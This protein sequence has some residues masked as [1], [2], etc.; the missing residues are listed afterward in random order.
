M[1][2][3]KPCPF[4]GGDAGMHM[5]TTY[6]AKGQKERSQG[7]R[8][9]CK[10]CKAQTQLV[11]CNLVESVANRINNATDTKEDAKRIVADAWNRRASDE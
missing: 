9:K 11:F 3:L 4:C 6:L 5:Q 8:V 1:T 2:E 7:W 10:S